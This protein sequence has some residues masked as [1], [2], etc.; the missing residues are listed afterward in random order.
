M[1]SAD[2]GGWCWNSNQVL[3]RDCTTGTPTQHAPELGI[4]IFSELTSSDVALTITPGG[5]WMTLDD[6]HAASVK[7]HYAAHFALGVPSGSFLTDTGTTTSAGTWSGALVTF[8]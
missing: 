7:L 5:G 3:S 1:G 6:N 2:A 4:S 8:Y